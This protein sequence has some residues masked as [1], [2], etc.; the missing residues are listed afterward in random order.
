MHII[1]YAQHIRIT[2]SPFFYK[3]DHVEALYEDYFVKCL[4]NKNS[5]R[6]IQPVANLKTAWMTSLRW[7]ISHRGFYQY[8]MA[9]YL[10]HNSGSI[11][12]LNFESK[13]IRWFLAV[14]FLF[15]LD[16]RNHLI[17]WICCCSEDFPCINAPSYLYSTSKKEFFS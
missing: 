12:T 1:V 7:P 10:E 9:S 4:K 15:M 13:A 11:F 14:V 2:W 6:L 5:K 16:S 17:D 3:R 8:L